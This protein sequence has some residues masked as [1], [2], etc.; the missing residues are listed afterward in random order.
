MSTSKKITSAAL[1]LTTSVWMSGA[2]LLVPVAQA[3]SVADLQAQIAAL[4]A[5]IQQLQAQL[6]SAQG[7]VTTSYN[8]TRSL[9]VGSTGDDVRALQQF[10]NANGAQVAASGAGSPGNETTYF[11]SLTQAAVAKWQAA[12]GV[13]PAVGYFG[14]ITR[15]K[16]ASMGGTTGG[17]TGGGTTV[18]A[19][20]SGLKVSLS[21]NNPAAGSLIAGSARNSILAVNL[22]AGT[23]SGVTVSDL[24]FTK[25]GVVADNNITGAYLVEGGKVIAQYQSLSNGVL[26]FS[27]LGL[28]VAAGQTRELWLQVDI[29]SS[30]NAGNTVSFQVASADSVSSMDASGN[31]ITET[32]VPVNGNTFTMT[33]VSNPSIASITVASSSIGTSVTAGTQ[34]NLVGAFTFTGANSKTYLK[35]IKFTVIGS[36][37]KADIRNVK[38]MVN[39][40]QVGQTLAAVAS[41]GSAYFDLSASPATVNTGANNVQ[42]Y[43]DV[44][45]SPSFNFQFEILNAYD[46]YAVDSQYNTPVTAG[47]NVG[48]Q[49]SIKQG[50]ITVTQDSSTPTGNI[51]KGQSGV[52]LAKFDFYAA[53]EPV[54]VKFL[55]FQLAFTGGTGNTLDSYIKNVHLDDDAGGQVGSTISSLTTTLSCTDGTESAAT[56]TATKCFGN[57]SSPI[58]YTIPANTTRVLSLRGDVQSGADFSTV[59]AS[60]VASTNNNLQ[61]LTSSQTAN[62]GSATGAALTLA[63]SQLTTAKN[64]AFGAPTYAANSTNRKIGSYALTASSAEGVSISNVSVQVLFGAS[65]QNLKVMVGSTQFGSTQASLSANGTFAFSGA[66]FT[67]PSG[68]TTYVD[69][70]ADLLSNASG[71][72]TT[73]TT[74]SSCTGSG[75]TSYTSVTCTSTAGQNVAIAG[76]PAITISADSSNPSANQ[77]VM[78]ST[79]NNLAAFLVTETS[80]ADDVKVTD[81]RLTDSVS[82][83][84]TSTGFQ[85]LCL[86]NGASQLGCAGSAGVNGTSTT[87]TYTFHFASP[88]TITKSN[89]VVLTLKGDVASFSSSG[90]IDNE[91]HTFKFDTSGD[92]SNDTA[93]ELVT[94]LG[95]TSNATATV[96]TSS[97][98]GNAQTLLRTKLTLTGTA[99]GVTTGRAKSATDDI[100]LLNFAADSAGALKLQSITVTFSGSGPS[101][102]N[103]F[104]AT[105]TGNSSV[106]TC[107]TCYVTLYDSANG[108]SYY[109][110]ASTTTS[111][112]FDLNNYTISAGSSK[113][114]TLRINSSQTGVMGAAQ[115]GVSQTLSATISAAGNVIWTDAVSGGVT[116]LNVPATTIPIT[117]NSVSYAAGS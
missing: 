96:A 31:S 38:L 101:T 66:P 97:P 1:T 104:N 44:M 35:N 69:V 94:V 81:L 54:K 41:D 34:N 15:A 46:V 78:G 60:L 91:A 48:T 28:N 50:S 113:S 12:N 16:I 55:S 61:G 90:A 22:T 40:T 53:G 17:T 115:N 2:L 68:G 64:T 58:N 89:S 114:F 43:A 23:A 77:I 74:L 37:N 57:S 103:F 112:S 14:P 42:V 27:G 93:A 109:A 88:V 52:T 24:K 84:S 105:S 80:N 83:T 32:G 4:L 11:G 110:V 111:L 86:Y 3:Q 65:M 102:T 10:L 39:G 87:Y 82:A 8:F 106:A 21:A 117:V 67:V 19:P 51:A 25:V 107:T 7:G 18:P 92:P 98:N 45:G 36:A 73:A 76:Q 47:S 26:T 75:A 49:V 99:N 70:Y 5:Q 108:R 20:A 29:S 56:T 116:G 30:V 13:S 33:T 100:G 6:N 62:S 95:Q 85:N 9:T 79:G 71:T 59:T 63:T 72:L